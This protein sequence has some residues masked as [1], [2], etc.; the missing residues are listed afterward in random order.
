MAPVGISHRDLAGNN[1]YIHYH[2]RAGGSGPKAGFQTNAFPEVIVGD[3]GCSGRKGDS[4]V[5]PGIFD[6]T[7]VNRW[8]D[9][10]Q[11][12][13]ILRRMCMTHIPD[14]DEGFTAI[15]R[16]HSIPMSIV[17][18]QM[19]EDDTPYSKELIDLLEYFE[20]P[21]GEDGFDPCEPVVDAYANTRMVPGTSK[22]DRYFRHLPSRY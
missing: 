8:E 12:G 3:F 4:Q 15:G 2:H 20:V 16:P 19:A 6:T 21:N 18:G 10:W 5:N 7:A 1:I 11:M 9:I 17:N 13:E 22:K 14:E